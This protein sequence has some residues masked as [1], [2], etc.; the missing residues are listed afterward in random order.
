MIETVTMEGST[1]APAPQKFE[2]GVPMAAQAIGLAAAVQYLDDLGID[3]VTAHEQQLAERL[4]EGLAQRPWVRV[5][6]PEAG[7][8]DRGATV[9]FVVDGVHAHDVGPGAGRPPASPSGSGTTAP[10]RCTAV[11]A[12]RDDSGDVR[13][14]Q[15]DRA[16]ST[17]LL[18]ALDRRTPDLRGGLLMDLYQE[19]ILE[20]SKRPEGW[21]CATR[22]TPR[23][24]TSTRPAVTR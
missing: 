1:Y 19:L 6:G 10:G 22:S 9:A 18:D 21:A 11:R 4:V 16:R 24:T 2:A 12:P 20:H 13:R 23:C 3:R 7:G 8:A 17:R 14:L 15:H 5:V